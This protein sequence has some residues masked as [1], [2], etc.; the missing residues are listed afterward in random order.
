MKELYT[1]SEYYIVDYVMFPHYRRS[2]LP[3]SLTEVYKDFFLT[4]GFNVSSLFGN[5]F[6]YTFL[7]PLRRK[8]SIK[9]WEALESRNVFLIPLKLCV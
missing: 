2:H 1:L 4:L 7:C 8:S 6:C 3:V 9:I 5:L